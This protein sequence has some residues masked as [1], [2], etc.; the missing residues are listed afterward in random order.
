ML[1]GL[2][3]VFA[4]VWADA[5]GGSAAA[6]TPAGGGTFAST[7]FAFRYTALDGAN[8]G[9][10]AASL[11]REYSRILADLGV[12]SMPTVNVTFY[13]DHAVMEAATRAAAGVVPSSVSGLITSP[14]EIHLMS[15]NAPA[16]GPYSRMVSNLVHEFAHCV[17]M[18]VNPRIPN[19]PRWLWESV[20]IYES[21]QSV[22]LRGLPY[23]TALQ[24]PSFAS[25]STL[26]NTRVYDVGYSIAEF[27][28]GRWG[29]RG[30]VDLLT[31]GGD[32]MAGVGI[33]QGQFEQDW[34]TSARQRYAF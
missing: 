24:P 29:Q 21:G 7:H 9:D 26:D 10:I 17:S 2:L 13:T 14:T 6:P 12:G 28:V 31:A 8:I 19:N 3:V 33:S 32:T 16:W 30:L 20:A 18:R 11:E 22:D 34:F 27:V 15:P 5:C 1:R 25:M 4:M 23:M